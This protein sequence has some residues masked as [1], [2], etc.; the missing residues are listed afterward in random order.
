MLKSTGK[1]GGRDADGGGGGPPAVVS[2]ATVR[3]MP[4]DM[5]AFVVKLEASTL[6]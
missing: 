3:L 6:R 4:F 1:G 5:R 2:G